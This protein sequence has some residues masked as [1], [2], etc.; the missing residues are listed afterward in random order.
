MS[1]AMNSSITGLN[2][3]ARKRSRCGVGHGLRS[4]WASERPCR[5]RAAVSRAYTEMLD[6]EAPEHVAMEAARRVY[7]YHHP[8]ASDDEAAQIVESWVFRGARH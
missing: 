1:S 8:E 2:S 3:M 4:D 6:C 7:R 5:C